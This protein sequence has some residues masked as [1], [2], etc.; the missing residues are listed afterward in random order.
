MAEDLVLWNQTLCALWVTDL[1][2]ASLFPAVEWVEQYPVPGSA[3][4][5]GGSIEYLAF[6]DSAP[7][8]AGGLGQALSLL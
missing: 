3:P 8:A 1:L 4:R 6:R 5:I 2:L 7:P